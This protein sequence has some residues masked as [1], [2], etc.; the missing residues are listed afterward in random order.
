MDFFSAAELDAH[1]RRLPRPYNSFGRFYGEE[2]R[3]DASP[4]S[5]NERDV[6]FPPAK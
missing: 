3:R 5:E 6:V 4:N 1:F 2:R